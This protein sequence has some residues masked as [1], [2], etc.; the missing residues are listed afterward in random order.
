LDTGLYFLAFALT[1]GSKQANSAKEKNALEGSFNVHATTGSSLMYDLSAGSLPNAGTTIRSNASVDDREAARSVR[2]VVGEGKSDD[3]LSPPPPTLRSVKI[4]DVLS[5]TW[6]SNT[7]SSWFFP[8]L[9]LEWT[10][11]IT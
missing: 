3:E 9:L 8:F 6:I 1:I 11:L 7:M 5:S 2:E 4:H 10:T